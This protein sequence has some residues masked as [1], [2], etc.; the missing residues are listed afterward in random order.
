[1]VKEVN[2]YTPQEVLDGDYRY[3]FLYW[4]GP[5]VIT[6]RHAIGNYKGKQEA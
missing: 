4:S 1:M 5:E 2:I 3:V 6:D